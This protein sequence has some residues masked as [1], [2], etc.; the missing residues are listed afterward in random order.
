MPLLSRLATIG[1]DRA[2]AN[3]AAY[4]AEAARVAAEHELY[5]QHQADRQAA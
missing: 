5:L 1:N 2:A 4:Q 3:A